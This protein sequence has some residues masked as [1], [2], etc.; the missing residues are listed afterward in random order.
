M[1]E[2]AIGGAKRLPATATTLISARA[3]DK[4]FHDAG[5]EVVVLRGL[6]MEVA[7]GEEIAIIGQS[8]WASPRCC[9]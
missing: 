5:R 8:G 7:A 1:N 2:A 9:T 4:G 6:D 3:V